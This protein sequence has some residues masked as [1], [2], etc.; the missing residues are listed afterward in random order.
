LGS[1]HP[2]DRGRGLED[3]FFF[4][5][6]ICGFKDLAEK[7]H[8]P[9]TEQ[10]TER[11]IGQKANAAIIIPRDHFKSSI[12]QATC[13][14][15]FT[16]R[17][18]MERDYEWRT[19]IDTSTLDLSTKHVAWLKTQFAGNTAYR[20]LYGDF[21][22]RGW[23]FNDK[24]IFVKQR[25]K[26]RFHKEPNFRASG[27]KAESI[28]L[29]FDFHWY[30]DIVS[31][32][33][34]GTK[35]MRQKAIDHYIASLQLLDPNGVIL[36]TATRWHDGDLTGWLMKREAENEAARETDEEAAGR[37]MTFYVRSA[38]GSD[39]EALFPERWSLKKLKIK[40]A[41]ISGFAWQSQWM[42]DPVIPEYAIPFD[43]ATL[44]RP[45]RSF[46][47]KLR[48]KVA[49][50][51]PAFKEEDRASGDYSVIV[52]GGFDRFNH[53]WGIDIRMGF[54]TATQFIDQ[55]FDVYFAWR[56]DIFKIERKHTS[57]MDLALR[58]AC[59]ETGVN[60][61]YTWIERDARSKEIRFQNLEP[62]FTRKQVTFAE[63]I[64]ENVKAELEEELERV[65]TSVHDDILDAL[66]DQFGE[67]SPITRPDSSPVEVETFPS[68][69][70]T[71]VSGVRPS[72]DLGYIPGMMQMNDEEIN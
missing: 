14:W 7:T 49:T 25:T 2:S 71:V 50:I 13:L 35:T 63:E 12:G 56:P 3:L 41:S 64:A 28:G 29:H 39:G 43:H 27:I 4:A 59:V 40:K 8:R 17:A 18:I 22:G 47:D 31:E 34:Y 15:L 38:I 42:N 16:R 54:W 68:S 55:L 32:R 46:P 66:S 61:P 33:N 51:D 44:Y 69:R 37:R 67:R 1:L 30:D 5:R 72:G 45:R 60:L 6:E 24:E 48:L 70:P 20:T 11:L 65:G 23:N 10:I 26:E 53:W 36:Y 19:M 9:I 52:V 57:W 62:M 58:R 21:Y